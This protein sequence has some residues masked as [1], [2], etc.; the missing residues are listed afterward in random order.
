M[1]K[2]NSETTIE[3]D[4]FKIKIGTTDKKNPEIIYIEIGCYI[5]PNE[6]KEYGPIIDDIEKG[7]NNFI[8]EMVGPNS[9]CE[10]DYIFIFD[11]AEERITKKKKSY[12]EMQIFLK[13]I[14][15]IRSLKFSNI[16]EKFKEEYISKIL[17]VVKMYLNNNGFECYKTRK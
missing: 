16:V 8:G 1:K 10:K 3:N 2:I 12:M 17:P 15:E 6:E 13:V 7:I 5:S 4:L 14:K 11:I 9:I